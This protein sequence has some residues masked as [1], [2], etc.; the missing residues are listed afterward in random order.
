MRKELG[1]AGDI[2]S[3]RGTCRGDETEC[4]AVISSLNFLMA[5][6]TIAIKNPIDMLSE[7]NQTNVVVALV[8]SIRLSVSLIAVVLSLHLLSN[9]LRVQVIAK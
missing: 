7:F 9:R 2:S 6:S 1:R 8:T 4:E 3:T 5:N